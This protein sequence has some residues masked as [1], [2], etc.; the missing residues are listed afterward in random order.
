MT[1]AVHYLAAGDDLNGILGNLT[2]VVR[3]LGATVAVAGFAI[4]G[5]LIIAGFVGQGKLREHISKILIIGLGCVIIG[6]GAFLAPAL[7]NTGQQIG[8]GTTSHPPAGSNGF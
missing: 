2:N 7:I 1:P 6:G 4:A 8:N 5:L 3:G